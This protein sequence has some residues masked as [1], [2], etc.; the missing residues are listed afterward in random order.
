LLLAL[1]TWHVYNGALYHVTSR[2]NEQTPIFRD[3][4]D[5]KLFSEYSFPSHPALSLALLCLCLMTNH[6]HLLVETLADNL[7]E[8]MRQLNGVHT[9][10]F[11]RQ[12]GRVGHLSGA[13]QCDF[14]TERQSF[15]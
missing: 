13:V 3:D 11:N 14:G 12:H 6:Y 5:R 2:G 1:A 8:D 4:A 15:S 9:Q 7:S 10:A